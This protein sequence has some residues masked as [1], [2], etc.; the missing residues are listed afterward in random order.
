MGQVVNSVFPLFAGML[1]FAVFCIVADSVYYGTLTFTVREKEFENIGQVI[2]TLF[3]P[4]ALASVRSE[5]NIVV[6]PLNNLLY[7]LDVDNLAQHG[8]H[9]RYTHFAVN[10]PLLFGPLAI[11]ALMYMP[12]T[13]ARIRNDTNA[14]MFYGTYI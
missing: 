12:S 4:I 1:A 6:T 13:F 5:G 8:I 14:H 9:P 2:S 3:N 7:N 11:F 10:L